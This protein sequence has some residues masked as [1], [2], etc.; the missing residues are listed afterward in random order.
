MHAIV[1]LLLFV[2]VV[3]PCPT[4]RGDGLVHIAF[5]MLIKCCKKTCLCY[6][7]YIE[8]GVEELNVSL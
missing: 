3:Y 7:A 2:V 5:A 8:P 4:S 6:V 1:C